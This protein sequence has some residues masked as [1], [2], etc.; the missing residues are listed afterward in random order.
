MSLQKHVPIRKRLGHRLA[1]R[2]CASNPFSDG[3]SPFSESFIPEVFNEERTTRKAVPYRIP[4]EARF[5]PGSRA[6]YPAY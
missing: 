6:I 4:S 1:G 5:M 2:G 3:A